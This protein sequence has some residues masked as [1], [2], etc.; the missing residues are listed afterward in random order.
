M[1]AFALV[2]AVGIAYAGG[3]LHFSETQPVSLSVSNA[4]DTAQVGT[5][6]PDAIVSL[7][8]NN[9]LYEDTINGHV[10]TWQATGNPTVAQICTGMAAA[11]NAGA[12]SLYVIAYDSTTKYVVKSR[13][14]GLA[15][16]HA[17]DTA[18][19]LAATQA[20]VVSNCSII[21]TLWFG[22]AIYDKAF[23]AEGIFGTFR[24][25]PANVGGVRGFGLKDTAHILLYSFE[26]Q[27]TGF[28]FHYLDS[29]AGVLPCSLR[30]VHAAS[31]AGADTL[32]HD[33]LA[34]IVKVIDS[35]SDTTMTAVYPVILEYT[36]KS[37]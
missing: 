18:Q 32:L 1:F 4:L 6:T 35:T 23:S 37:K 11:I 13:K 30:V 12:D 2:I 26:R 27:P 3:G 10:Y 29:L 19:T 20:N 17:C 15:F 22:S 31:T 21:D 25:N 24:V 5:I 7:Q 36:L 8:H 28:H 9:D 16:T 33:G 34:L 14:K